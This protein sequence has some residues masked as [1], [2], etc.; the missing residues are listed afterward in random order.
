MGLALSESVARNKEADLQQFLKTNSCQG[1][2]LPEANLESANLTGAFLIGENLKG[3]NLSGA[4]L[5]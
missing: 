1:C 3:V 2:D 5:T 4:N